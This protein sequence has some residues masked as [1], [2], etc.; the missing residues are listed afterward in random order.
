MKIKLPEDVVPYDEG[1]GLYIDESENIYDKNTGK[2]VSHLD[3]L[4]LDQKVVS[5]DT[6]KHEVDEEGYV[7]D[8]ATGK[9]LGVESK[10]TKGD[11]FRQGI[12]K[13]MTFGFD[14]EM[15]AAAEAFNQGGVNNTDNLS[16]GDRYKR[17]VERI[18]GEQEQK[19][20]SNPKTAIA[21]D[22]TGGLMLG[23][24]T[25]G[26]GLLAGGGKAAAG[27]ATKAGSKVATG[28]VQKAA[29]SIAKNAPN[30]AK[31]A[32]L[33]A[34]AGIGYGNPESIAEGIQDAAGGATIG[35]IAPGAIKAAGKVAMLPV[36]GAKAVVGAVK[37][38]KGLIDDI[39]KPLANVAKKDNAYYNAKSAAKLAGVPFDESKFTA[40]VPTSQTLFNAIQKNPQM[41]RKFLQFMSGAPKEAVDDLIQ[42]MKRGFSPQEAEK[43]Y[44]K[45]SVQKGLSK[46]A[47]DDIFNEF[48]KSGKKDPSGINE[49]FGTISPE[50]F[51]NL[52]ANYLNNIFA[53]DPRVGNFITKNLRTGI[54]NVIEEGPAELAGTIGGGIVG[55][56]IGGPVGTVV[57]G[58]LGKFVGKG[59]ARSAG[60]RAGYSAENV[61]K[62]L[63]RHLDQNITDAPSSP[64]MD[65]VK[66]VVTERIKGIG[67]GAVQEAPKY[68]NT[69]KARAL[70]IMAST[71]YGSSIQGQ[72][73]PESEIR[74]IDPEK[75]YFNAINPEGIEVYIEES[76]I[77][78]AIQQGFKVLDKYIPVKG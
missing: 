67:K 19:R 75:T 48:Y 11:T 66:K 1:R 8:K 62:T 32:T 33:G 35:M 77:N 36:K 72:K 46:E 28:I 2:I 58:G 30:A 34:V 17:E 60:E 71:L 43:A 63:T 51:S 6:E 44:A 10:S 76:D 7:H 70:D 69:A 74:V 24:L 57:G 9:I 40:S 59:F 52:Q 61:M 50:E 73:Q 68:H 56:A 27:Q 39:Y 41:V 4:P 15:G 29:A 22:V 37:G 31:S 49:F 54:R 5:V 64:V 23:G 18:R 21:G 55:T 53:K 47:V 14:D 26:A 38:A 65:T 45:L 25:G 42:G 13:G 16:F 78:D 20:R 12:V 3:D